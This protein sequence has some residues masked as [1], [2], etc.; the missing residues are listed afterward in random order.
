MCDY[1]LAESFVPNE[2]REGP[3]LWPW[4][5]YIVRSILIRVFTATTRT[6]E[7]RPFLGFSYR[8]NESVE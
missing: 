6:A 1:I 8:F 2:I 5:V 3:S 7:N 4:R